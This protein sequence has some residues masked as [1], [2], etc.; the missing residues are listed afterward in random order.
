MAIF[1]TSDWHLGHDRI[2]E[3]T[4][5][6][7]HFDSVE[8]M[9]KTIIANA[10]SIAGPLDTIRLIGDAVMGK[11]AD[12]LQLFDKVHASVELI[13]GNHDY[14]H[15]SNSRK[16][17]EKWTPIYEDYFAKVDLTRLVVINGQF[18]LLSHVPYTGDSHETRHNDLSAWTPEDQGQWLI[19]GHTHAET[20]R[21]TGKQ[22]HVGIDALDWDWPD[23]HPIPESLIVEELGKA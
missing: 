19:H 15:P 9:N 21:S 16:H 11:R 8:Q 5:R 14:P 12:N 17:V 22:I 23:Y 10:N 20:K 13:L 2:L 18:V 6:G 7:L 3:L 4:N 1:Y